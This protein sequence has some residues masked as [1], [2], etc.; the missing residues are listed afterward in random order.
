[1]DT[2]PKIFHKPVNGT[3]TELD[4]F[5]LFIEFKHLLK[6]VEFDAFVDYAA[7]PNILQFKH[8]PSTSRLPKLLMKLSEYPFKG[9]YKSDSEIVLAD[10]L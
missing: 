10:Y 1:M 5:G 3:L 8:E 7:I 4:L 9:G 2:I 6:N